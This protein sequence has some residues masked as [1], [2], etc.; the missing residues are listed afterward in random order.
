MGAW[1]VS[2][3]GNDDAADPA[4]RRASEL[5]TES[6]GV[7]GWEGELASPVVDPA[8]F[9]EKGFSIFAVLEGKRDPG[10]SR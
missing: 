3:F 10:P 1:D 5:K 2:V 4:E 9:A 7:P 8:W 6:V